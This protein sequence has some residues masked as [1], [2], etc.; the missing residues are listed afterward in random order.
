MGSHEVMKEMTGKWKLE[1]RDNNFDEFLQCRQ[2]GWFLRKLM[3]NG[4]AAVEYNLSEDAST[5]TK[6]TTTMRGSSAY[7]MPTVGEFIPKRTLSGKEETGR[8]FETSGGNMIQ[9]MRYADSGEMAATIK[10]RVEDGKL[11]IDMTCK[12]ITC[13]SVYVKE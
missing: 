8:I 3:T 11:K 6:I 4:S 1:Q 13:T 5:F 9:E 7:P 10:H 2:V 12:N